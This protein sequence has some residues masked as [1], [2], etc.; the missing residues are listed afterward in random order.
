ME[1]SPDSLGSLDWTMQRAFHWKLRSL[2]KEGRVLLNI[3]QAA[4][5]EFMNRVKSP[6]VVLKLFENVYIE[7]AFRFNSGSQVEDSQNICN[8]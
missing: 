6:D 4:M 2:A 5:G 3:P 1:I 7:R 8:R